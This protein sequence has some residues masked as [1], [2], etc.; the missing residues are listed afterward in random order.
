MSRTTVHHLVPKQVGRRKGLKTAELPTADLC[1]DCHRQLHRLFD[2][3]ELAERLSTIEALRS[4]ER[5][6]SFLAWLRK[7]SGYTRIRVRG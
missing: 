7:Q 4:D 3:R 5:V 1:P 6:A 2:N